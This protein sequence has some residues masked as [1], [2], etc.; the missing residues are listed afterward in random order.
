MNEEWMLHFDYAAA[1]V[2]EMQHIMTEFVPVSSL[3]WSV[4]VV[5]V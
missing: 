1:V 2:A 3:I 4:R 5:E